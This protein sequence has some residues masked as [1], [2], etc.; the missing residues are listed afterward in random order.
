MQ[1][2]SLVSSAFGLVVYSS[3]HSLSVVGKPV[4]DHYCCWTNKSCWL[5]SEPRCTLSPSGEAPCCQMK[6]SKGV[7]LAVTK[8]AVQQS[9]STILKRK[10]GKK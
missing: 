2:Y 6:R 8:T 5:V 1:V 4:K 10:M 7:E 9:A 3:K